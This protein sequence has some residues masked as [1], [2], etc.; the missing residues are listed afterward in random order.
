MPR[1][2]ASI[3]ILDAIDTIYEAALEPAKWPAALRY[4]RRAID[5]IGATLL[6]SEQ[7]TEDPQLIA[8][9]GISSKAVELY[10]AH[11]IH[12]DPTVKASRHLPVG[13]LVSSSEIMPDSA[14]ERTEL[15]NDLMRKSGTFYI[16]GSTLPVDKAGYAAIGL[17]RAKGAGPW[18]LSEQAIYK[19]L[20]PH[21]QRA[22]E[23]QR[24][25]RASDQMLAS[26]KETLNFSRGGVI[27]LDKRGRVV[28]ANDE[29][30]RI[31]RG[32]DGLAIEKQ[33]LTAADATSTKRLHRC[34]AGS[35]QASIFN[36]GGTITVQRPS[37]SKSYEILVARLPVECD[38]SQGCA[39][40]V[41]VTDPEQSR[42][43]PLRHLVDLY[44]LTPSEAQICLYLLRGHNL[45]EIAERRGAAES[46]VRTQMKIILQKTQTRR[47]AELVRILLQS[48]LR[49]SVTADS[50][51]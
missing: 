42:T 37:G 8:S 51:H 45:R 19:A 29:A 39:A 1:K 28:A 32:G 3:E 50:R 18:Q 7:G 25:L 20:Q 36:S 30:V 47:Q 21:F 24:R 41:F 46:T 31:T 12:I 48:P 49:A 16:S 10:N 27:V 43:P 2:R 33:E 9:I 40:V 17:Q 35:I 23:I 6:L 44:Q 11:Y 13:S 26:L 14:W 22:L 34:I 15:Y 5:T 4:F 38:L